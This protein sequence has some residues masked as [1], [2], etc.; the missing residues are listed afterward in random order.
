MTN[1]RQFLAA[2]TSAA[3]LGSAGRLHAAGPTRVRRDVTTLKPNDP[4][5]AMYAV[6]VARMHALP[7]SDPRSWRNQAL[8]HLNNCKHGTP[9]F[10]HWHRHYLVNF[11]SI[12][13]ELAGRPD[14]ALPYWNWSANAGRIP[15]PF[16]DLPELNVA[17]WKDKSDAASPNWA[18][19]RTVTTVGAR[20]LAK[21]RGLQDDSSFGGE[22]TEARINAIRR[23]PDFGL[24]SGRLEGSPHGMAHVVTGGNS[25]H[26]SSGLSPLDPIFWLHHCNVDRIWA[27][28]QAAGNVSPTLSSDYTGN[29]VD[30]AQA[31][32]KATS[33][34]ALDI[35]A[36]NFTYD[37]LLNAGAGLAKLMENQAVIAAK[38]AT[39]EKK[40]PS[41]SP[42]RVL[43]SV[44]GAKP[45]APKVEG[46]FTLKAQ[47]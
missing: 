24:F 9:D 23:L 26:M 45:V 38:P 35:G 37:V 27:Q 46:R 42:V 11:E 44:S 15:D 8:I 47:D 3:L 30:G 29:F 43:G 7:D 1:R 14:F 2:A 10:F 4:F 21:G 17:H 19:G 6:A 32:V 41:V 34:G 22:F 18:S 25:G 13:A 16:Y 36:L 20:A 5:F 33:A 12:C 39:A 40:A 28:W 31:K